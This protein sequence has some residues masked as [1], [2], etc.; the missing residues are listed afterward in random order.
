MARPLR[1][2]S[3]ATDLLPG[4]TY[5]VTNRGVDRCDLF[6]GDC[7]R[8]LFLTL[9]AEACARTGVIC[10]AFCLMTNHFH[11]VVEDRRG[12]LSQF[13]HRFESAYARIFNATRARP[14]SG[15]LFQGRFHSDLIDSPAYFD[16]ACAYV[17]NNPMRVTPAMAARP[18]DY[19]WSSAAFALGPAALTSAIFCADLLQRFGGDPAGPLEPASIGES[20][21]MR[22]RRLEAFASGEWLERETVLGGRAPDCYRRELS[23][24]LGIASPFGAASGSG[25]DAVEEAPLEMRGE[26]YRELTP[27]HEGL[28]PRRIP[29][30]ETFEGVGLGDAHERIAETC[31]RLVPALG[32]SAVFYFLMRFCRAKLSDIARAVGKTTAAVA[33]MVE[34]VRSAR[35]EGPAWASVLWRAEWALQ[36]RL[37]AAP[38]CL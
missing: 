38:H 24:R 30:R 14:R 10:H 26:G 36:W 4:R 1:Y 9:V 7:D 17:V 11:L 37:L 12:T 6:H 35:A 21:G 13:M 18:D 16:N 22:C 29:R 15:H 25:E 2:P 19:A 28:T 3:P 23:A 5:H 31:A 32:D 33:G 34:A 20:E 27:K 8:L